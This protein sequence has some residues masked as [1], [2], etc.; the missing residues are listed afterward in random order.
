MLNE[1]HKQRLLSNYKETN[2]CWEW[3]GSINTGGYGQINI[4]GRPERCHR[5]SWMIF[6]G[7]IPAGMCVLHKCDNRKCFN[8][9]HLFLGTKQQNTN[10]MIRK[11]RKVDVPR[12]GNNSAHRILSEKDVLFIRNLYNK[13]K[14]QS[15]IAR[16]FGVSPSAIHLI[17]KN[18]NWKSTLTL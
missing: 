10:D 2:P 18:K 7:E 6:K 3:T 8:P 4:N 14:N 1:S 17:V 16:M 12:C 11:G 13:D 5:L 15:K 9:N